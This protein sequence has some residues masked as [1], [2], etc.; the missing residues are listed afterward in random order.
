MTQN[1]EMGKAKSPK[2]LYRRGIILL[3]S[4]IGVGLLYYLVPGKLKKP[5]PVPPKISLPGKEISTDFNLN[6]FTQGSESRLLHEIGICDTLTLKDNNLDEPACSPRFFRFFPLKN[7]TNFQNGFM[8]LVRSGVHAFPTRRLLIF[9]RESNQLV[10]VNGFNGYLIERRKS[11]TEYDDIV[12]RFF[13]RFDKQ[14]YFYHCLFS[15]D[16]GKYN[17]V[18]CEEINDQ[19]VKI[20]KVDSVS[21]V[22]LGYLSDKKLIF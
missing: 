8:L 2:L 20:E 16:Q 17:Y 18:K 15:W 3:V 11:N 1:K 14:K 4:I 9:Q 21:K 13:E 6:T 12:I 10:Q 22:V 5:V 19:K 7:N